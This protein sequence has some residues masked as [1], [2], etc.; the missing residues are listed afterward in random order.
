MRK[1][2]TKTT[3]LMVM[4]HAEADKAPYWEFFFRDQR[5]PMVRSQL[6]TAMMAGKQL[7]VERLPKAALPDAVLIALAA[8]KYHE[9]EIVDDFPALLRRADEVWRDPLFSHK[10]FDS[11]HLGTVSFVVR[12]TDQFTCVEDM[13]I[14]DLVGWLL[15]HD[16][17]QYFVE[18]LVA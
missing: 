13:Y 8:R 9:A 11:P 16:A 18:E 14:P 12:G 6:L 10:V 15:G 5:S 1:Q 2:K 17:P 7:E 4:Q 3:K